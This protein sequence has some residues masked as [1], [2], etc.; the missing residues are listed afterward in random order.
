MAAMQVIREGYWSAEL[1]PNTNG[2]PTPLWIQKLGV[3][4]KALDVTNSV[5]RI[6]GIFTCRYC[7]QFLSTVEYILETPTGTFM[8]PDYY[9]HYISRHK[10]LPSEKFL[11]AIDDVDID[12]I[13]DGD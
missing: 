8:W 11:C 2:P 10:H 5:R 9:L 4:E 3:V 1:A 12:A 13:L 7:S 6:R